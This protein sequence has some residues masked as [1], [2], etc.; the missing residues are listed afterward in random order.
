MG[1]V[2]NDRY[3]ESSDVSM[4]SHTTHFRALRPACFVFFALMLAGA[5]AKLEGQNRAQSPATSGADYSGMYSFLRDGEF[6]Q[7]TVEDQGRVTGFVSRYGDSE[8]IA[9]LFWITF[10]NGVSSMVINSRLPRRLCMVYRSNFEGRSSGARA[11]IGATKRITCSGEL[12][13]RTQATKR[14]RLRPTRARL[15]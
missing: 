15:R 7:I 9:A 1:S 2:S 4:A 13:S 10:S 14:R 8:K 5:Q 3:T 12:S 11:R 6:V